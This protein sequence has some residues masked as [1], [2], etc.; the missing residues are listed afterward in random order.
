MQTTKQMLEYS[1]SRRENTVNNIS[2]MLSIQINRTNGSVHRRVMNIDFYWAILSCI[3]W[4]IYALDIESQLKQY[5]NTLLLSGE[6]DVLGLEWVLQTAT[7]RQSKA[8]QFDLIYSVFFY[9]LLWI[10]MFDF[11]NIWNKLMNKEN[12]FEK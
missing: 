10:Q 4:R 12:L 7:T 5:W 3:L 8:H 6:I 11:K 1:W 2:E 9:F